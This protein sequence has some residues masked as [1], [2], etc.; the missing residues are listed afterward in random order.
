MQLLGKQFVAVPRFVWC[1]LLCLVTFALA[2]GGR[3]VLEEI[4]NNLLSML[5]YWT[6]AFAVILFVEHFYFRPK[7]G[8]YDL[9]AWQDAKRLPL[10]LAGTGSLLIGIGFSFLSMCQTWVRIVQS[11]GMKPDSATKT[12][13]PQYIAPIAKKIGKSGGDLGDELT[14]VSVLISYPILR[15]L[16][17]R[18]VGR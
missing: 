14:L 11:L 13:L 5:G 18:W 2:F 8:G 15:T 1:T 10:G 7:I 3:N 16:E 12:D 17:L 9:G 4:I 6:L